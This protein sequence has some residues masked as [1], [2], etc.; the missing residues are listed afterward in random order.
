MKLNEED[1]I[2]IALL[3]GGLGFIALVVIGVI[4]AVTIGGF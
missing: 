1:C 3:I 4:L 2:L